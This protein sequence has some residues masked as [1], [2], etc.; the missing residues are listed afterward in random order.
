[1]TEITDDTMRLGYPSRRGTP[2]AARRS[3]MAWT[4]DSTGILLY[5]VVSTLF[6]LACMYVP[7]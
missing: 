1:V 5:T 3:V 4:S 2:L 6:V 7:A